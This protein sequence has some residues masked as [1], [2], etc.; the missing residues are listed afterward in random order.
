MATKTSGKTAPT[1]KKTAAA[2]LRDRKIE[3][4]RKKIQ[5]DQESISTLEADRNALL[6]TNLVG[7]VV[8]HFTFGSGTVAL[9]FIIL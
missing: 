5:Q 4:Y 7:A 3:A 9:L 6:S 2:V 1:Q 8:H